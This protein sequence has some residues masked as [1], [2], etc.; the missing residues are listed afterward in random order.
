MS[1]PIKAIRTNEERGASVKKSRL[2][3]QI[4]KIDVCLT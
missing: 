2:F 1:E 3:Q 4:R